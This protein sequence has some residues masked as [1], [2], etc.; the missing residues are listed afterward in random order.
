MISERLHYGE[1]E[2]PN[3]AKVSIKE[4]GVIIEVY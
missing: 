4:S 1:I 3:D 2:M